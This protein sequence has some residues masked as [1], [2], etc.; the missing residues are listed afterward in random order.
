MNLTA[1]V[2]II[3]GGAA[4]IFAGIICAET[5][6]NANV[7]V[8]EKSR[9]FLSKVRIS[10]GGRCNTT[11]SCFDPRIL[12]NHYPRGKRELLGAFY[13]WQPSD[14]VDWYEARGVA[15]KTEADGRMFPTTD[16]SQTIVDCLLNAADENGVILKTT[17]NIK[18]ASKNEAGKFELEIADSSPLIVDQ[19]IL[20]Q[21]GN[22]SESHYRLA[23]DFGHTLVPIVPSLFSFHI[24]DSRIRD[25][26]GLSIKSATVSFPQENLSHRG[27]LLVTHEGLSGPA[28]LKL[29]AFGA[30]FFHQLNYSFEIEI[31]WLDDQ[32]PEQALNQIQQFKQTERRKLVTNACPF[33]LPMRLWKNLT[34]HSDISA[35]TQWSQVSNA[36]M[37]KLAEA[38]T[39][40]HYS[41][42]GKSMNKEEFVTAGGISLNEVNFKTMESKTVPGLRFAGEFLDI[43]GI[44]GGFNFQ[45]AWTTGYIA[46]VAAAEAL[47]TI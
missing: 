12:V 13:T 9:Q 16:D 40:G 31:N 36:S 23:T 45:A 25:L 19:L 11:H 27:P 32:K 37:R 29:S 22:R 10:G 4:G 41:V 38:L 24:S 14:T 28:I 3:G 20:A 6:P 1:N 46:G 33:E 26:P 39:R 7:V 21:G 43:D 35:N 42:S 47:T 15:L 18:S 17:T 44:T 30:H 5:N 2:A 34:I 8:F